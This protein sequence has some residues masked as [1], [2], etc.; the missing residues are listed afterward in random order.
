MKQK[1]NRRLENLLQAINLADLDGINSVETLV[2]DLQ[3]LRKAYITKD[4]DYI[5]LEKENYIL[6][7]KLVL[8]ELDRPTKLDRPIKLDVRV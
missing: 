5:S 3:L 7:V 6:R 8:K 4:K 1:I 2:D